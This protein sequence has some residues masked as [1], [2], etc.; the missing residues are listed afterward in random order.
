MLQNRFATLQENSIQLPNRRHVFS[1]LDGS[2]NA[3]RMKERK[4]IASDAELC[5]A[6]HPCVL[7][8]EKLPR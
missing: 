4:I 3:G 6:I 5:V 1:Y 7:F 2:E 8:L